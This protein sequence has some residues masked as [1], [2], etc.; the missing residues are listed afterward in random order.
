MFWLL[1]KA[2]SLGIS[3][4]VKHLMRLLDCASC[5]QLLDM[6]ASAPIAQA[7]ASGSFLDRG[8][9]TWHRPTIQKNGAEMVRTML[10]AT[11]PTAAMQRT[12]RLQ[13]PVQL[14]PPHFDRTRSPLVAAFLQKGRRRRACCQPRGQQ[15]MQPTHG[16]CPPATAARTRSLPGQEH[17]TPPLH[18]L[19]RM[20]APRRSEGARLV[21]GPGP[22][23]PV[24]HRLNRRGPGC[25]AAHCLLL[26][27]SRSLTPPTSWTHRPRCPGANGGKRS[28]GRACYILD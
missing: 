4:F 8:R 26:T 2:S 5:G 14:R 13:H 10:G 28:C 6:L 25:A 15:G 17:R 1:G 24:A 19:R 23:P 20:L 7:L 3:H 18:P 21:A 16:T 27:P 9:G 22:G 11:H 12:A